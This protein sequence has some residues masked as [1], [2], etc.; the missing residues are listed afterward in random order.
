MIKWEIP[1]LFKGEEVIPS[2]EC[3]QTEEG[4]RRCLKTFYL[5]NNKHGMW[6]RSEFPPAFRTIDPNMWHYEFFVSFTNLFTGAIKLHRMNGESITTRPLEK[7]VR[8]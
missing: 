3:F 2:K 6:F 4:K 7:G 1:E 5:G 8:I